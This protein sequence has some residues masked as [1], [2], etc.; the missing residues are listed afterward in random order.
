[1]VKTIIFTLLT[2][3]LVTDDHGSKLV[4]RPP[5]LEA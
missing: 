5:R 2:K 1:M 3:Q 4:T